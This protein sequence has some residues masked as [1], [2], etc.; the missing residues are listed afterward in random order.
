MIAMI[1]MTKITQKCQENDE[2]NQINKVI[3]AKTVSKEIKNHLM[4]QHQY[5]AQFTAETKS[6]DR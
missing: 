3:L 1:I 5:S 6:V 4:K 2:N